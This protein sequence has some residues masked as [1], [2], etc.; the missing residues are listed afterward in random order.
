MSELDERSWFSLH[1]AT[2]GGPFGTRRG[3]TPDMSVQARPTMG[4]SSR[5]AYH[6]FT[7]APKMITFAIT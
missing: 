6:Q 3:L 5:W 1:I 4:S 7:S 2:R